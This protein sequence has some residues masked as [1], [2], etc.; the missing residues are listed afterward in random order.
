MRTV[1]AVGA[2]PAE[3]I[4]KLLRRGGRE[5]PALPEDVDARAGEA[6]LWERGSAEPPRR[7]RVTGPR[8][9]RRRHTRKYAEGE[10]GPDRSFYFRGPEGALNLRAQNLSMFVQMAE[11]VDDAT[12]RHHLGCRRLLR[13]GA[14]RDQGRRA[15]GRVRRVERDPGLDPRASREQVKEAIERRYTG[16]A[17]QG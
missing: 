11:G 8:Q 7:V 6:L 3:T 1:L 17:T 9:E 2:E 14:R 5:P 4:R 15:R 10:L 13:V 16:P 12:W